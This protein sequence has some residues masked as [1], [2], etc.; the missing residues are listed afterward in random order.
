MKPRVLFAAA[1]LLHPCALESQWMSRFSSP[2][3]PWADSALLRSEFWQQYDFASRTS[4][5]IDFGDLD[6]DGL[7]DVVISVIDKGGR[8]PGIAIIHQIDRSVH[9]VGAGQS[10]G[11]RRDQLRRTAS[12]VVDRLIGHRNGIRVD[13]WLVRGWLVWNGRSYTWVQDS[14]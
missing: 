8:R 1:V 2:L 6:G 7:W 14:G 10:L 11:N 5:Q 9:I 13:D 4:P 3:P 12:W